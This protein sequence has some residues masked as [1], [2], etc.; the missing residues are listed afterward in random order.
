[1]TTSRRSGGGPRESA[2]SR[3][4]GFIEKVVHIRRVAKVVK[5]GKHFRFTAVVVIG[6]DNGKVGI[7]YGK[8]KEV[9]DAVRKATSAGRKRMLTVVM[10]GRTVPH[11]A[12]GKFGASQVL[13]K[14]AAPGTGVI[15]GG[16]VRAVLEAVGVRD[17]L[18]KS[19]GSSN[20][21]NVVR[22]TFNALSAMRDPVKESEMRRARA[23]GRPAAPRPVGVS[24]VLTRPLA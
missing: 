18:T 8:G 2:V 12:Y 14:P 6:D 22:A 21:I 19:L 10:R 23:Q 20:P 11:L 16:P 4:S 24:A 7:G 1:L 13:I 17:V 9:P 3:D 15:A 5:G